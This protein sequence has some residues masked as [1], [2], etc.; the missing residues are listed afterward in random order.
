MAEAEQIREELRRQ[1][2]AAQKIKSPSPKRNTVLERIE[3]KYVKGQVKIDAPDVVSNL[4]RTQK[5]AHRSTTLNAMDPKFLQ[6]LSL[7]VGKAEPIQ[8]A[9]NKINLVDHY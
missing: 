2:A 6:E 4:P 5:R 7:K 3:N 1:L 8:D 9:N